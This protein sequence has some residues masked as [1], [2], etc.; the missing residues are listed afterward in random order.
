MFESLEIAPLVINRRH[1]PWVVATLLIGIVA[2]AVYLYAASFTPGGLTGGSL[3]GMWYGII[4]SG[5]MVYAGLLSVLRKVPSWW[6]L[7][8]RSTWLRGHIWLGLLSSLFLLCHS[9]FRWGGPVE[10]ALWIVV[11]VTLG[12]GIFGLALQQFIPR[13]M[14]ARFPD[15]APYEQIPHLCDVLRHKADEEVAGLMSHAGS[16]EPFRKEIEHFHHKELRPFLQ[17]RYRRSA[18]LAKPLQVEMIFANLRKLAGEEPLRERIT[19]L[20]T[21]CNERRQWGE[22]ERY[23]LLLHSWL[24]VHVPASVLVLVLGTAHV[25]ASLYY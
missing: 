12:T 5:L 22:L 15:E 2:L 3:L 4:G 24:L 8:T 16:S 17:V 18:L 25:V 10:L 11:I 1:L 13:L 6:W 21:F 20:E 9:G 19:L 14:T 7:G 23:Y